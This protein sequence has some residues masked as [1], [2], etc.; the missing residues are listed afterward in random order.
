VRKLF[1]WLGL[2]LS[3][4][5]FVEDCAICKHAEAK[6][7]C[8]PG[9]LQLLPIPDHAWQIVSLDFIEGLLLSSGYDF[10]LVVVDKFFSV[11]SL[12]LLSSP[13]YRTRLCYGL[14]QQCI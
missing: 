12:Y 10:I 3:I 1:A 2:K 7:V 6:R 4:C 8:Y 14:S 13:F 5:E 11:C 9:L